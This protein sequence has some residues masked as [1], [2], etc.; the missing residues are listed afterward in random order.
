[1]RSMCAPFLVG[2]YTAFPYEFSVGRYWF[3]VY[4]LILFF[5]F[6]NDKNDPHQR[7][8]FVRGI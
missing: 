6:I 5:F 2:K 1:M 3:Y 4:E 7:C 8:L